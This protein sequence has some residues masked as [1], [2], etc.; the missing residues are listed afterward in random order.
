MLLNTMIEAET[1]CLLSS[2]CQV[3]DLDWA[4]LAL[5]LALPKPPKAAAFAFWAAKPKAKLKIGAVTRRS[6]LN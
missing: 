1:E 2:L 3:L 6:D 5:G 4:S